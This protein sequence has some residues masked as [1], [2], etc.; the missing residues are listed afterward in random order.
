MMSMATLAGSH[1]TRPR[2]AQRKAVTP[3]TASRL[4]RRPSAPL[5]SQ[6]L[7][8]NRNNCASSSASPRSVAFAPSRCLGPKGLRSN[9]WTY[10][11]V[12]LRGTVVKPPTAAKI[13]RAEGV[14]VDDDVGFRFLPFLTPPS[15][16]QYHTPQV[17]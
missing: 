10:G 1:M 6:F 9:V 14:V 2:R 15:P 13:L 5:P 16:R 3:E 7:L 4:A 12:P 8:E 11:L 17:V